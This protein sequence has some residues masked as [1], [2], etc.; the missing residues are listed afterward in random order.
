MLTGGSCLQLEAVSNK[1]AMARKT[2]NFIFKVLLLE[3]GE[4]Q[5]IISK[6]IIGGKKRPP[7]I[8]GCAAAVC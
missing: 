2:I 1:K 6:Q 4:D 5:V 3:I 8:R 7:A